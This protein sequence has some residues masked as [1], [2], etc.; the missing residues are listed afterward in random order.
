MANKMKLRMIIS[1]LDFG[2]NL[3]NIDAESANKRIRR[4]M[5][6]RDSCMALHKELYLWTSNVLTYQ[7]QTKHRL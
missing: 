1:R 3:A 6:Y 2:R 5:R 4:K 7:K